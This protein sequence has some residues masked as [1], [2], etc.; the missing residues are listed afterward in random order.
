MDNCII[1]KNSDGSLAIFTPTADVLNTYSIVEIASVITPL[2]SPYKIIPI[3]DIPS[4]R[5]DRD[6]WTVED[7]DLTDG[8]GAEYNT[9]DGIQK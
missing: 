8:F 4:N 6:S 1:Y 2:G 9:F 7:S 5:K 3:T